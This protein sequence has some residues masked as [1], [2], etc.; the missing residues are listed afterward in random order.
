MLRNEAYAWL[1]NKMGIS[2]EDC[3]IAMFNEIQ[4]KKVLQI[5]QGSK[6]YESNSR[7]GSIQ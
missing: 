6:H 4:C 3:H 7:Q 5:I 1:S 2:V